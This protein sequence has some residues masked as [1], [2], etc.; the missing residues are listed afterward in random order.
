MLFLRPGDF[1]VSFWKKDASW[2]AWNSHLENAKVDT[3]I[4]FSNMKSFS[5]E[6]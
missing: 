6:C 4:L 5:H 1:L 3:G 2:N